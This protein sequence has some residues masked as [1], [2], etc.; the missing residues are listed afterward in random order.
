[1]T[2]TLL[3]SL[4]QSHSSSPTPISSTAKQLFPLGE[5]RMVLQSRKWDDTIIVSLEVSVLISTKWTGSQI[6]SMVVPS[7]ILQPSP[8]GLWGK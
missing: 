3:H 6:E 4:Q 7:A 8:A 1:M 2:Q 5:L